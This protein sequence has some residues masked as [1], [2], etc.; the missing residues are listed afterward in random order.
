[1]FSKHFYFKVVKSRDCVGLNGFDSSQDLALILHQRNPVWCHL[2]RF[3]TIPRFNDPE[4]EACENIVGQVENAGILP[5]LLLP[6]FLFL[7]PCTDKS[8][9]YSFWLVR[10]SVRLFVCPQK[11]LH[12]IS[13]DFYDLGPTYFT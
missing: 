5:F 9:A 10:L 12:F 1:M 4:K 8:G 7:C 6:Q 2:N 11:N 3:N 13:L